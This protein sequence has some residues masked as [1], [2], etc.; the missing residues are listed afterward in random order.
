MSR[1]DTGN[2][3][4]R[5]RMPERIHEALYRAAFDIWT[6]TNE[7]LTAQDVAR[8]AVIEWLERNDY[9]DPKS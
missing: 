4:F 6:A 5:M 2:P 8:M 7:R 9:M 3:M 1:E